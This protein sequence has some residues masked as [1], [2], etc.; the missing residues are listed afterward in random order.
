MSITPLSADLNIVQSLVI[1]ELDDDLDIIQKLDDEPNDV[2]GL[3][4]AQL[5]A[6]FDEGPNAIRMPARRHR[7]LQQALYQR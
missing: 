5:K 6:K 4:A 2:G 1:P 7:L 3:T